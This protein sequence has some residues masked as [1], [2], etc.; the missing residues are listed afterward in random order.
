MT[1]KKDVWRLNDGE[2]YQIPQ[3]FIHENVMNFFKKIVRIGNN[4]KFANSAW[5]IKSNDIAIPVKYGSPDIIA[6][7]L[8][9][10]FI[11]E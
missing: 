1:M 11:K 9:F 4:I 6:E 3:I 8:G 2:W 7:T 5:C 10:S